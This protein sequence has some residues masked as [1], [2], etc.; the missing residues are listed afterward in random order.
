MRL[1]S[2]MWCRYQK[3][4][5]HKAWPWLPTIGERKNWIF[6]LSN[7]VSGKL[8]AESSIDM[9]SVADSVSNGHTRECF[10]K[11]FAWRDAESGGKWN[12]ISRGKLNKTWMSQVYMNH[13]FLLYSFAD[14]IKILFF[15][16]FIIFFYFTFVIKR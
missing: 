11:W 14:K 2:Q 16:W 1:V 4:L 15:A 9:E 5:I 13:F 12:N 8:A 10:S 6:N 7:A 3:A